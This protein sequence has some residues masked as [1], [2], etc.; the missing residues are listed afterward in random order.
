MTATNMCS[1]FGGFRCRP[2]LRVEDNLFIVDCAQVHHAVHCIKS[3]HRYLVA[4]VVN[5]THV[6]LAS[7][8]SHVNQL[9]AQ[10]FVFRQV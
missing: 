9:T 2:P 10:F 1:N 8:D 3:A 6:G 7:E 4:I 5:C